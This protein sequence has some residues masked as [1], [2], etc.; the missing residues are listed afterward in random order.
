M[1]KILK[2]FNITKNFK[3][4]EFV[5][6]DGNKETI[7]DIKAVSMLQLLRDTFQ[8]PIMVNSA[9]RSPAYNKSIG[10]APKSK[11][12][13]GIAFDISIPGVTPLEVGKKALQIGFKG[14]GVYDTFTH[15]DTRD[16]L[17]MWKGNKDG[18]T[19]AVKSL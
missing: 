5:C 9:Y 17:T 1:I 4:S 13:E 12:M 11:H 18:T 14:V 6:K 3:I 15:V 16:I 2:D 8:K 10:G 7:I 19:T